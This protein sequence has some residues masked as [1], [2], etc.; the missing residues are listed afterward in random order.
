M[1]AVTKSKI[2][3]GIEALFRAVLAILLYLLPAFPV[4]FAFMALN[5]STNV[6]NGLYSATTAIVT[7]I[8]FIAVNKVLSR[9]NDSFIAHDRLDKISV[10]SLI[11][12]ALGLI[13]MV[14]CYLDIADV[15][16]EYIDSFKEKVAEYGEAMDRFSDVEEEAVPLW[17]SVIY[18]IS[19]VILIPLTEEL[20]FRGAVLGS[21]RRGFKP[22]TAIVLSAL[23]FGLMHGISMHIG[24]A[25]IC[26][27]I[28]GACYY[29]TNSIYASFMIHAIF[30]L[31]GSAVPFF[32]DLNLFEI[33]PQIRHGIQ[34]TMN[35]ICIGMMIPAVC[36]YLL[37]MTKH[38]IKDGDIKK[39]ILS[40]SRIRGR[41]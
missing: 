7:I 8:L 9:S 3:R 36:A 30:N 17:D 4:S 14:Y 38:R 2:A 19:M 16:S 13:G 23:I 39:D 35:Y 5:K 40:S 24:Y 31:V 6:Y 37:L 32:M 33:D 21:L 1:E 20:V 11:A 18:M 25:L 27:L 26:G 29:F 12:I 15:I 41:R 34:A 28:I 10:I 22:W